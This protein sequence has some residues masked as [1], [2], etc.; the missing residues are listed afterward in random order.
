MAGRRMF[1]REFCRDD[2]FLKMP[3][4][5]QLL[6]IHL[7]LDADDDG[8]IGSPRAVMRLAGASD[9]DMELLCEKNYLLEFESGR[10]LIIHWKVHNF[11]AKDRY[12]KSRHTEERNT[13]YVLPGEVYSN[14]AT[15]EAFPLNV[16]NNLTYA[17]FIKRRNKEL[18]N[19]NV[20]VREDNKSKYREGEDIIFYIISAYM[21]CE[22]LAPME[23]L[24]ENAIA[25]AISALLDTFTKDDIISAIR[26]ANAS[27]FLTGR[28]EKGFRANLAWILK[29]ERLAKI[30]N[31]EYDDFSTTT[32]E[33]DKPT[34]RF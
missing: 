31:G 24:N 4:S 29:P 19:G 10:A 25:C 33:S 2:N 27:S 13:V 32:G 15:E 9:S 22:N 12:T 23:E 8:L 3:V 16:L 11:L 20:N 17:E 18:V 34:I 14:T 6:Y 21:E 7:C 30:L 26:K 1:S 28:T 5:A